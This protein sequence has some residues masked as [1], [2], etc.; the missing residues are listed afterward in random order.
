MSQSGVAARELV[1]PT[2]VD[3]HLCPPGTGRVSV[4]DTGFQLGCAVFETLLLRNGGVPF[5]S[6]HLTRLEEGARGAG[7]P[8]PPPWEPDR[9]LAELVDALDDEV[10]P[11]VLRLTLTRGVPGGLP[12]LAFTVRAVPPVP[13]DGVVAA[14]TPRAKVAERKAT[15]PPPMPPAAPAPGMASISMP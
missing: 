14:L 4:E 3:G 7:I 11:L 5:L 8:W 1:W 13:A 10:R 9:A 6:A 12:C 15:I 2:W